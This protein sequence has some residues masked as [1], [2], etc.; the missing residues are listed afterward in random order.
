LSFCLSM[1]AM[2]WSCHLLLFASIFK[3]FSIAGRLCDVPWVS[4]IALGVFVFQL[5]WLSALNELPCQCP[6]SGMPF[7]RPFTFF[8][9]V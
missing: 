3:L 4:G 1:V 5:S 6:W 8:R 2:W 7:H 9:V